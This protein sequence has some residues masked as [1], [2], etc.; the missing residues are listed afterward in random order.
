[1]ITVNECNN[2]GTDGATDR[3]QRSKGSDNRI[4]RGDMGDSDDDI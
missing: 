1:M 3:E 2:G 4:D